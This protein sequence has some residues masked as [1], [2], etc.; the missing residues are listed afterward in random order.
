MKRSLETLFV[1]CTVIMVAS[2]THTREKQVESAFK[3]FVK[4]NTYDA[5]N[6][7]AIESV[8]TIDTLRTSELKEHIRFATE[9]MDSVISLANNK[10]ERIEEILQKYGYGEKLFALI[11]GSEAAFENYDKLSH[12]DFYY[13][14][15]VA[16]KIL[17]LRYD[18]LAP[19]H[20]YSV[21]AQ[22]FA[23][24]NDDVVYETQILARMKEGTTE[25]ID[26]F[27]CYTD[28]NCS[29][30]DFTGQSNPVMLLLHNGNIVL[31]TINELVDKGEKQ[32]QT[33]NVFLEIVND[34]EK[35]N[36]N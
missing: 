23:Y 2:C 30:Y 11:S 17:N 14:H 32:I 6:L 4:E 36:Q 29:S 13:F 33:A 26:T 24:I 15:T 3:T 16:S 35:K 31:E 5:D 8:V 12:E 18:S 19:N 20:L 10:R 28:E 21:E 25:R 9:L 27:F 22:R 1:L 7:I 34:Y